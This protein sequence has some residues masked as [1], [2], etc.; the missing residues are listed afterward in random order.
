M[1]KEKQAEVWLLCESEWKDEGRARQ[2]SRD[3]PTG[4]AAVVQQ[5]FSCGSSAMAGLKVRTVSVLCAVFCCSTNTGTDV[6][7]W[8]V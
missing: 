6:S 3:F 8:C 4:P 7:L 5:R 2:F 1:D